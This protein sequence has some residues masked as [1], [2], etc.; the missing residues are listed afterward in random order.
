MPRWD[1]KKF[2]LAKRKLGSAMK[3]VGEVM[4]IGKCF[5][6][7]IQKAIRMC[8]IG[9]DGLVANSGDDDVDN[10]YHYEDDDA[11][12]NGIRNDKIVKSG[13][14]FSSQIEKIEYSL[15]YPD[16][17]IIFNIVKSF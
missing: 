14:F 15:L 13:D 1:F 8:E 10:D 2:E 6:E 16:D 5:E 3:S 12:N 7:A 4:A 9:K 17:E 11:K